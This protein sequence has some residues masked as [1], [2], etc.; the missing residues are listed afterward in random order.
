MHVATA[1]AVLICVAVLHDLVPLVAASKPNPPSS[2]STCYNL[3]HLS[4]YLHNNFNGCLTEI[5]TVPEFCRKELTKSYYFEASTTSQSSMIR[6][7][8]NAKLTTLITNYS[9]Y[10]SR[11]LLN[12]DSN[13]PSQRIS[14]NSKMNQS[15]SFPS[16][17]DLQAFCT[18]WLPKSHN[19]LFC[20][21]N[22]LSSLKI[23]EISYRS[24][25][26][27]TIGTPA[28]PFNPC[29][30]S[31]HIQNTT[32]DADHPEKNSPASEFANETDSEKSESSESCEELPSSSSAPPRPGTSVNNYVKF[33]LSSQL[34][35]HLWSPWD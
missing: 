24:H 6:H 20:T 35:T 25:S 19:N 28:I 11:V 31:M 23:K 27:P 13:P 34:L 18:N 5:L 15:S 3:V 8:K 16:N 22:K 12:F 14:V 7:V 33:C 29:G 2:S 32:M 30:I 21:I 1:L 26:G 4:N 10:Y 17:Y 9:P